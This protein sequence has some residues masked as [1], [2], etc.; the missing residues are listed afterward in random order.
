[1]T[2]PTTGWGSSGPDPAALATQGAYMLLFT[3]PIDRLLH[4]EAR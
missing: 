1:M 4:H 3:L 2:A